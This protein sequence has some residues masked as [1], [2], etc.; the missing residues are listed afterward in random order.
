MK[1]IS[2]TLFSTRPEVGG[3]RLFPLSAGRI[4]AL[5]ALGNPLGTG[6]GSE[7]G[8]RAIY[9]AYLVSTLEGQDLA[10]LLANPER[11][12]LMVDGTALNLPDEV[13]NEFW[14][15]LQ[16]ELA[17]ISRKTV[18]PVEDIEPGKPVVSVVP[19]R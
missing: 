11:W 13:L 9:E 12:K 7:V 15:V 1:L 17:A 6:D 4:E 14:E 10:H 5:R 8:V 3:V 16:D 2:H 19:S 18:E